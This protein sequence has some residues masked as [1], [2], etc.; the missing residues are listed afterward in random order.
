MQVGRVSDGGLLETFEYKRLPVGS[1]VRNQRVV[2]F[3][4][5]GNAVYLGTPTG[6]VRMYPLPQPDPMHDDYDDEETV[7]WQRW[8][9]D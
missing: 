6:A 9:E 3:A 4:G 1:A 8:D 7:R 5:D 2:A